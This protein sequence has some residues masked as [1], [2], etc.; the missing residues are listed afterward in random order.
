MMMTTLVAGVRAYRAQARLNRRRPPLR[1][2]AAAAAAVEGTERKASD[3]RTHRAGPRVRS[4]SSW[5]RREKKD[6]ANDENG[7]N[8]KQDE[9]QWDAKIR[10]FHT[11]TIHCMARWR[12]R[13]A[14]A[15]N[16]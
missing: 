15:P 10:E 6:E 4:D 13:R 8:K 9:V 14:D 16:P 11:N 2:A 7:N 1:G 12:T 5:N 3:C